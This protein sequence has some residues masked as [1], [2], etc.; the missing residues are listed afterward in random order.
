MSE[1][2]NKDFPGA[3]KGFFAAL[4][5]MLLTVGGEMIAEKEGLRVGIG[6]FLVLIGAACFYAAFFWQTARNL[7]SQEAQI[8][9]G[10]FARSR[11]TWL[12]MFFLISQAII[13]S[14][15]IEQRRW[16]FSY[17]ADPVVY[18]ENAQ[19]RSDATKWRAAHNLRYGARAGNGSLL[20]CQFS[21]AVGPSGRNSWNIWSNLQSVLDLA[22]WQS[23]GGTAQRPEIQ[24]PHGITILVGTENGDAFVCATALSQAVSEI[25]P[26]V[27]LKLDQ[28]TAAL[29]ACK[30][31]CVELQIGD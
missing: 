15:F 21:L 12:V 7:L 5:I 3:T 10:R 23:V 31:E 29:V 1:E 14:K 22:H 4:G 13:L 26:P 24:L 19:L 8:A 6:L 30:N 9:I 20:T 17:P 11:A 28:V 18:A 25:F 2:L 27:S 16:P